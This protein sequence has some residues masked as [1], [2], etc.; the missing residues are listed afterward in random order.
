MRD[1]ELT[2]NSDSPELRKVGNRQYGSFTPHIQASGRALSVMRKLRQQ[3]T[4][5]LSPTLKGKAHKN[6]L[7]KDY[8]STFDDKFKVDLAVD[9]SF[10]I[11]EMSQRTVDLK[12]RADKIKYQALA[13]A[14][15]IVI[16]LYVGVN[17]LIDLGF[18]CKK[19]Y[20]IA[21]YFDEFH[22]LVIFF[23]VFIYFASVAL[24]IFKHN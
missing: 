19:R 10:S 15:I 14:I 16:I 11:S 2:G 23:C 7:K 18:I 12:I 24:K 4:L 3:D 6:K 20:L 9:D 22:I 8:I 21:Q 1:R 17:L 5:D 13:V